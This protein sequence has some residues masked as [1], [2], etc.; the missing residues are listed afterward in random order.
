MYSAHVQWYASHSLA[1]AGIPNARREELFE[2]E[3]G[4]D[5]DVRLWDYSVLT[6]WSAVCPETEVSAESG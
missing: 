6:F 4:V 3:R 2:R 1:S 5:P